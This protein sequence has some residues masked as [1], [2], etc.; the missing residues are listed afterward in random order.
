MRQ[1]LHIFKKDVRHLQGEICLVVALAAIFAWKHAAEWAEIL[2]PVAAVY[3]IARL[4]HAEAIPGD[5]QF[6]ITRPYRWQS[7]LAAKVA[8]ILAFVSLP[9]SLAQAYLLIQDKFPLEANW[10]ALLWS[11]FMTLIAVWLPI[12]ALAAMTS[13]ILPF[14]FSAI[15]LIAAAFLLD[16]S[17]IFHLNDLRW[18]VGFQWLLGSVGIVSVSVA[19]FCVLYVQYKKRLTFFSRSFALTAIIVIA[20]V[21][22]Y[23]P[24]SW[25]MNLQSRLPGHG[26]EPAG[27]QF[28]ATW[29]A[30]AQLPGDRRNQATFDLRL[31]AHGIPDGD[32]LQA[33][34]IRIALKSPDGSKQ[35]GD[36]P[37][38]DHPIS[39][40]ALMNNMLSMPASFFDRERNQPLT[41]HATAYFT[42]FGDAETKT[43]PL[44]SQPQNVMD[45][46]RCFLARP[47]TL[48]SSVTGVVVSFAYFACQS[49][50]RWP[51][52][53]V[54]VQQGGKPIPLGL[55]IS[56]SPFPAG[57][58][59][60]DAVDTRWTS[61]V[62]VLL[63]DV[64][65]IAKKPIAHFRRDFEID[66]IHLLDQP[67]CP[68]PEGPAPCPASFS[69]SVMGRPIHPR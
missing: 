46:L 3:L 24:L 12:A 33:D 25:A 63:P 8:F 66:N 22:I 42:I 44:Q 30:S 45:G 13:S 1:A 4:I 34:G 18:P 23:L 49:P 48:R 15:V 57:I 56:Y 47:G 27:L 21:M 54:Q 2:L 31:I 7:L 43:I 40:N 17:T 50:F 14:N 35:D 51:D 19:A 55:L 69:Q 53:F 20:L 6:W 61:Q 32:D 26:S 9:T 59:L 52:R 5:R 58:S 36:T 29:L 28:E 64:T 16:Q 41:M 38:S 68:S 39:G 65:V 10:E 37:G 67:G 60:D 11:Q 62:S